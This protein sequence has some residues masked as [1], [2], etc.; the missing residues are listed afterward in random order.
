M[1]KANEKNGMQVAVGKSLDGKSSV[2]K[3]FS[4]DTELIQVTR[5]GPGPNNVYI[6]VAEKTFHTFYLY[7]IDKSTNVSKL[8][9]QVP[10]TALYEKT[11]VYV[12][13]APVD[14]LKDN[15]CH[16]Y[17]RNTLSLSR[18][19]CFHTLDR[20]AVF[21]ERMEGTKKKDAKSTEEV[22]N[23]PGNEWVDYTPDMVFAR[24]NGKDSII[25]IHI[26]HDHYRIIDADSLS[27]T[28]VIP[29]QIHHGQENFVAAT[30]IM[31]PNVK[32]YFLRQSSP[33]QAIDLY[34]VELE[35]SATYIMS[36]LNQLSGPLER[37]QRGIYQ[38]LLPD[39]WK[40]VISYIGTDKN[41]YGMEIYSESVINSRNLLTLVIVPEV[42]GI[43]TV[44]NHLLLL[45][46][47]R[48]LCIDLSEREKI[49]RSNSVIISNSIMAS[50]IYTFPCPCPW[51]HG[52]QL[53]NEDRCAYIG[54]DT[55]V[56]R[57]PLPHY[58]FY[59]RIVS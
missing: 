25:T 24:L 6:Y 37:H 56:V 2:S 32:L 58:L 26:S 54:S 38:S 31:F 14:G 12:I 9:L 21:L 34:C 50:T 18:Y 49:R 51:L 7:C 33:N 17:V 52:I 29:F 44:S 8:I 42:Q 1:A 57:I 16:I 39:L 35:C 47:S 3:T 10:R 30:D 40:I 48:I 45:T 15:Q 13:E 36:F 4:G 20:D 55:S 41:E 46:A 28:A 5:K 22:V 19:L 27:C 43:T 53:D 11:R 59:S 23:F